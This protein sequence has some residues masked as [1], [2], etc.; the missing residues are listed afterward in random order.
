MHQRSNQLV[1]NL[2]VA[3]NELEEQQD[4]PFSNDQRMMNLFLALDGKLRNKIVKFKKPCTI[5]KELEASAISLEKTLASTKTLSQKA[6]PFS[7]QNRKPQSQRSDMILGQK[8]KPKEDKPASS[9]GSKDPEG[10]KPQLRCYNCDK[11]G[12]IVKECHAPKKEKDNR[13]SSEKSGDQWAGRCCRWPWYNQKLTKP[14]NWIQAR[15][16]GRCYPALQFQVLKIL[17]SCKALI[18]FERVN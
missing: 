13:K 15:Q 2:I 11:T 3:L 6:N 12:H 4:P 5:R 17:I 9:E 10:K 16:A 14:L 8:Q 1:Q 18:Q 7:G